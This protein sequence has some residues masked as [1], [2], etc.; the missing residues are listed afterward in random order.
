M[1]FS[2]EEFSNK[3]VR[4]G[5][6]IHVMTLI[7][8]VNVKYAISK[9][10]DYPQLNLKEMVQIPGLGIVVLKT[11][12]HKM[13]LLKRGTECEVCHKHVKFC[14]LCIDCDGTRSLK[15][16]TEHGDIFTIDHIEPLSQGGK[17]F[18]ENL[19]LMCKTCNVKRADKVGLIE[20]RTQQIRARQREL[21]FK[22]GQ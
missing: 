17:T 9:L 20:K 3:E 18:L 7:F 19:Q 5:K 8:P 13:C 22:Y 14:Y 10:Q 12:G 2:L 4:V 15:F 6:V 1:L 16:F 11:G 21:K